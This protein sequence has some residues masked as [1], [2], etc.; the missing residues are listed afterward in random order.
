MNEAARF[1][2]LFATPDVPDLGRGPR[3]GVASEAELE[4]KL[5][6]LFRRSNLKPPA[7]D[8]IR[9]LVLLWHDHLDA[10]HEI[11]QRIET[12]DGSYLHG[13]VHRREPDYGNA[14]YWFRR[15]GPHPCL[16]EIALRAAV[17][18]DGV[19]DPSMGRNLISNGSLDA[20]AFVDACEAE[21]G[22]AAFTN[23][24]AWLRKIQRIEFEVLLDHFSR[25]A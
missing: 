22:R 23:A 25:L 20:G 14:K 1:E 6:G 16:S 13:M 10:A 24:R 3:E 5:D 2:E 17:L 12:R 21:A 8:Q 7:S 11:A 18:F 19:G 4:Q 15:V 9:S